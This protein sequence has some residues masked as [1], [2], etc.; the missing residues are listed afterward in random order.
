MQALPALRHHAGNAL[1]GYNLGMGQLVKI[2]EV[3]EEFTAQA[4]REALAEQG[5]SC[6]VFN[7]EIPMQPGFTFDLRPWGA[8]LVA[9]ED[10]DRGREIA[11]DVLTTIHGPLD[12]KGSVMPAQISLNSR[13][14]VGIA[15]LTLIGLEIFGG[16]LFII[17][18]NLSIGAPWR[19]TATAP[20]GMTPDVVS[21]LLYTLAFNIIAGIVVLA[22]ML[23]NW[24]RLRRALA[25]AATGLLSL[26]LLTAYLLYQLL[27]AGF[28][29]V[30]RLAHGRWP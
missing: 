3:Y 18:D 26:P 30:L 22:L 27:R 23:L 6:L 24:S 10:Q 25:A 13:H 19:T 28:F 15:Y 17:I 21:I 11:E 14:W 7:N 8:V 1:R 9:E 16:L 5:I 12:G 4:V 20:A 2:A 29:G